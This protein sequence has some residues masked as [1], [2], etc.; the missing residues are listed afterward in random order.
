MQQD[1]DDGRACSFKKTKRID[2]LYARGESKNIRSSLVAGDENTLLTA[3][4]NLK[5]QVCVAVVVVLLISHGDL[6]S[7]DAP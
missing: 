7:G 1:V 6:D 4:L 5:P 2:L 3:W